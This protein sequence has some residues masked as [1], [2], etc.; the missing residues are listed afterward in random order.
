[1]SASVQP[2][3]FPPE[4]A[5]QAPA[6]AF[7]TDT[8]A[9]AAVNNGA[10]GFL[11]SQLIP[12]GQNYYNPNEYYNYYNPYGADQGTMGTVAATVQE[13]ENRLFGWLGIPKFDMSDLFWTGVLALYILPFYA[14]LI[15]PYIQWGL[16]YLRY[17]WHGD[18]GVP[19][20]GPQYDNIYGQT[21]S[22]PEDNGPLSE[23][24][25]ERILKTIEKK[26]LDIP[27]KDET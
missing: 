26:Q 11:Q 9:N 3:T 10:N 27:V 16:G 4:T 13:P 25:T 18:Y 20:K 21:A 8:V 23:D 2:A 17:L 19:Y 6:Q 7:N 12:T 22:A 1:M 24:T 15:A 14:L 5:S